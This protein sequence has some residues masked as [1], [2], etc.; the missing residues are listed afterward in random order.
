MN[1][2]SIVFKYFPHLD[3]KQ[4]KNFNALHDRYSEWNNKINLISR[5]DFEH[6]YERHVL[7]SLAIAKVIQFN[8]NAEIMDIG[9]GGGFPGIPLAIFFPGAK[10]TLV[11]SI[12]KKIKAVN[13][14]VSS[15]GLTNVITACS[16]AEKINHTYD[17]IVSR[18]TATV[19]DLIKWT[20]GKYKKTNRHQMSNGLICLK[21]GDLTEEIKKYNNKAKIFEI[22]NFFS[23][24]F[25]ETKKIV[26]L[27]S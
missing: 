26:F 13:G 17:F 16:R 7:H 27:Y 22:K 21:G 15:L 10:F 2:S 20:K 11:D 8:K 5:K 25:F 12:E 14:I 18:A 9:T 4:I 23:E 3:E 24:E 19:E 1:D 6:F